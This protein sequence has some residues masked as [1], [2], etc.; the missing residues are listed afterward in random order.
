MIA[1]RY[2][3]I[4]IVKL[5]LEQEGIEINSKDI[6]SL[7]LKFISLIS[8]WNKFKLFFTAFLY[9]CLNGHTEIA[10]LLME[11][12]GIDE[13]TKDYLFLLMIVLKIYSLCFMLGIYFIFLKLFFVIKLET[14]TKKFLNSF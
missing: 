4:E 12:E 11:Q 13:E 6:Y 10:S 9:A 14:T 3:N 7:Y 2:G 1:C 8:I 5:L